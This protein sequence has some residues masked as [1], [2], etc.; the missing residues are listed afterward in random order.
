MAWVGEG[1]VLP[2]PATKQLLLLLRKANQLA[3][4]LFDRLSQATEPFLTKSA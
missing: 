4:D 3:G 1:S 2:P